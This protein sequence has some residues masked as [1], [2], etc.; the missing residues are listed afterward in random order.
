MGKVE[1]KIVHCCKGGGSLSRG[2]RLLWCC[3]LSGLTV[4][5]GAIYAASDMNLSIGNGIYFAVVTLSTVGLGQYTPDPKAG[6]KTN[7]NSSYTTFLS[8]YIFVYFGMTI[9][10][11]TIGVFMEVPPPSVPCM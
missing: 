11:Y 10:T 7:V 4:L 2:Y 5:F 8:Y 9:I 1:N 6:S 3:G